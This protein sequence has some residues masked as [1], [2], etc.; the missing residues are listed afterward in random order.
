MPDGP[1]TTGTGGSVAAPDGGTALNAATQLCVDTINMYRA[2]LGLPPYARWPEEEACTSGEAL[3]DSQTGVAHSAFGTCTENAQDECPDWSGTLESI[4]TRCLA[5]MWA[6]GP[7]TGVAHG[8]YIN[9]SSTRYTRA[10]CGFSTSP[11][12]I[13]WATQNFK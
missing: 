6:E 10:A 13:T 3:T 8:H 2:T 12:G 5:L 1:L 9:M 4:V 7:G 11:T